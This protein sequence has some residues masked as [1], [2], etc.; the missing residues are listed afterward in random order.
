MR[1]QV[2][3]AWNLKI[4][5]IG[6]MRG[7]LWFSA[8]SSLLSV[9]ALCTLGLNFGT[10]F[11][12]G[13]ELQVHF[14]RPVS[15]TQI[16]QILDPMG[17]DDARVQRFGDAADNEALIMVRG[18]TTGTTAE[19]RKALFSGAQALAGNAND[20]TS[21][22]FSE[23][24]ESVSFGFTKQINEDQ[25]RALFAAHHLTIKR[26][27]RSERADRPDYNIELFSLGDKIAQNLQAGLGLPPSQDILTRVD[28]VGPLVGAQL[29][30]ESVMAVVYSLFFIL[31]YVALR[32]DLF[33]SPGA[34]IATL[35]DVILVLGVFSV[36]QFE[37]NLTGVAALLTLIG[38]SLNDTI[39][40][41]DR[42][43]ENVVRLRGRP[44]RSLV[45]ASINE[46]LSRT[47]LTSGT[48]FLVVAALLIFGGPFIRGFSITMF[49]GVIVGAY[50][51]IA[52]ASPLYIL[53]RE[54]ADRSIVKP[55]RASAAATG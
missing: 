32:F 45:N 12:G 29:R 9:V 27:G 24:G 50:S 30:T 36:C 23:G 53:L 42:I 34:I 8:I 47:I 20:L 26:L 22:D 21:W 7:I 39:V 48:V 6:H 52:V 41:F 28:F 4:D 2:P 51:S 19:A 13:Y 33:F 5:F 11:A 49:V 25:V 43:R 37:F 54:R 3:R 16:H 15:E 14:P 44:L 17:L 35:H 1:N 18:D 10:D 31:L 46:T 38:Y 55:K 40:V